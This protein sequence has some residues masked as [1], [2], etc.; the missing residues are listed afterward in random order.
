MICWFM[1]A[2]RAEVEAGAA[3]RA[4]GT[5]TVPPGFLFSRSYFFSANWSATRI[6]WQIWRTVSL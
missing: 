1:K 4:R 2:W 5:G 6:V 3:R